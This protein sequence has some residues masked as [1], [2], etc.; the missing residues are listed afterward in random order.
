MSSRERDSHKNVY[1]NS[2]RGKNEGIRCTTY[3]WLSGFN[4]IFSSPAY[5]IERDWGPTDT[6][7]NLFY[8]REAIVAFKKYK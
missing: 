4:Y 5:E 6:V 3:C 8:F 7:D 2:V 1:G